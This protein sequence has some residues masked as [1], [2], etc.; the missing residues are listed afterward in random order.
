[1]LWLQNC[2]SQRLHVTLEGFEVSQRNRQLPEMPCA[3][4]G[5]QGSFRE[6]GS[7]AAVS[8]GGRIGPELRAVAS[9]HGENV[10][11]G[12]QE[13]WSWKHMGFVVQSTV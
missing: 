5:D 3:N 6:T 4:N 9:A 13:T 1:M 11:K 2:A 8:W 7:S 10:G 12:I